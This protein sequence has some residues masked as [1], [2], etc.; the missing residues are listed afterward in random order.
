MAAS[1]QRIWVTAATYDGAAY[2]WCGDPQAP[3]DDPMFDQPLNAS[4]ALPFELTFATGAHKGAAMT[5]TVSQGAGA[6]DLKSGK[7]LKE[8]FVTGGSDETLRCVLQLDTCM[9]MIPSIDVHDCGVLCL[10]VWAEFLI[11]RSGVMLV[12]CSST[13]VRRF[14]V[15]LLDGTSCVTHAFRFRRNRDLRGVCW[16]EPHAVW[17]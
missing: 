14:W 4:N 3:L 8:F 16:K 9:R 11:W 12:P 13:K 10:R 6:A 7:R 5:A 2:G 1:G 17:W 15:W